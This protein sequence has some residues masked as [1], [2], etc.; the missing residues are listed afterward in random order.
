MMTL[1]KIVYLSFC[2]TLITAVS[3]LLLFS[4]PS[5]VWGTMKVFVEDVEEVGVAVDIAE[6]RSRNTTEKY[7]WPCRGYLEFQAN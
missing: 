3:S 6:R 2:S 4:P 7:G 1:Y 5:G